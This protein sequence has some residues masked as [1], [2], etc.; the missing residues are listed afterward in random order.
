M[1]QRK[2][3]TNKT[4][5]E[6]RMRILVGD[7]NPQVRESLARDLKLRNLEVDLVSNPQEVVAKARTGNYDVVVSDLQYTP[8]G[9]EGYDVLRELQNIRAKKVLYTAQSGFESESEALELGVDY[10]VS[11]KDASRLYK[12][13]DE[14]KGGN[15]K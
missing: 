6:R 5:L 4:N 12:L 11:A 7:D 15:R 14:L 10:F 13:L 9:R 2:K 3:M 1:A 8:E